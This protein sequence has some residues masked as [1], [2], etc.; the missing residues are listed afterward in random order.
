MSTEGS[1][2]QRKD[3]KWC[4]KY[5]D[6]SN[7]WK[8]IYRKT[9]GEAKSALAEALQ[10]RQDGITKTDQTVNTAIETWLEETH[11]TVSYRTWINRN[12]LYRNHIQNHTI[13]STKL[14]K[15]TPDDV[16]SFYKDKAKTLAPSTVKFLHHIL[17]KAF[18]D[19]VRSKQL[20]SNPV[21]EAPTPKV[22]RKD[23]EVLTIAQVKKL[24]AACRGDRFEGV[25][26]LGACC[27]TRI[28]EN[29]GL[30]WEDVDLDKGTIHIKRTLWQGKVYP[31]KTPHSRRLIKMPVI[32]LEALVRHSEK[33]GNPVE[34]Y[35]FATSN[36]TPIAAPNFWRWHW[37]PLLRRA[38]LPT[39]LTYHTLRHGAASLMLNQNV[40]IPI[41][42]K[43]L[44]HSNPYITMKVYSHMLPDMG[45][46]AASGIDDALG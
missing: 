24:L 10:D 22:L 37:K 38:G 17:N 36:G 4:A 39:T 34:G 11:S 5:K 3:G 35:V 6:A 8:Y 15:V 31:P 46:I 25:V 44:G 19:A 33:H 20:R 21:A 27:G 40:P 23:M 30:R 29:L 43:Y 16:R 26:V 45:G 28:N 2:F 41:V 7:R 1:V 32:V 42:S 18:R 14:V 13:G 12:G 9:K